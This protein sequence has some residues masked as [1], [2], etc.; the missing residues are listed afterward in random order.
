MEI[1]YIVIFIMPDTVKS[2]LEA[3]ALIEAHSQFGHQNAVFFNQIS[4]KIEPLLKA[5]AR[6]LEKNGPYIMQKHLKFVIGSEFLVVL[7]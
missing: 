4:Q 5:N 1:E 7:L 6:I 2:L 3:H